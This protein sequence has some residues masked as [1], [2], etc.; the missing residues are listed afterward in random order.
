MKYITITEE[1]LKEIDLPMFFSHPELRYNPMSHKGAIGIPCE[2]NS[3]QLIHYY[4]ISLPLFRKRH[5]AMKLL[6]MAGVDEVEL[7][8]YDEEWLGSDCSTGMKSCLITIV[9]PGNPFHLEDGESVTVDLSE[10][11]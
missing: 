2:F 1:L 3:C 6:R 7:K 8:H 5:K 9:L 10:E 4:E 11:L